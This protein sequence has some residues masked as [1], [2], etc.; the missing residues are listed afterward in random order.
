M[1]DRPKRGQSAMLAPTIIMGV[2]AAVLLL[3]GYMRGEG[4]HLEGLRSAL[5]MTITVLPLLLFAFV[6]AGMVQALVP[7]EIIARWVGAESG[8]RGI[9]IGTVA[10]GL[11]PGGPYV[12]LPIAAA[13]VRSG[14]S[15][16]TMV[17]FLT[18]WSLWAVARLPMEVGILGWQLMLARIA[19]TF[20]FPPIA[21]LI[22]QFFF[23]HSK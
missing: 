21:G 4:Q 16:G 20:F 9:A 8:L 19:S 10:G 2:L 3:A 6:V 11:A 18:A 15:T 5:I 7:T 17:A 23:D 12:S 13:L 14:A 1:T 22:A